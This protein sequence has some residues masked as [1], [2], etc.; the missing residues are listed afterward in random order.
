MATPTEVQAQL[1]PQGT[2]KLITIVKAADYGSS[3]L[4]YCTGG[5][6]NAG[7]ARWCSATT[8][9]TAAQQATSIT[10]AMNA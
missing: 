3:T 4:Y 10:T 6:G 1:D 2:G 7:R 9:N 5:I 8:A